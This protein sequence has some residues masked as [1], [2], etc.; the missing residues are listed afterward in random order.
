MR[1]SGGQARAR[2]CM[3]D[4]AMLFCSWLIFGAG[5]GERSL[6]SSGRETGTHHSP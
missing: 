5:F 4:V 6:V 1:E 2:L 3:E